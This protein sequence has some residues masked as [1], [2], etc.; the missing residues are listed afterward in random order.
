MDARPLGANVSDVPTWH[1]YAYMNGDTE[2]VQDET[3]NL[4][5]WQLSDALRWCTSRG[6]D[7]IYLYRDESETVRFHKAPPVPVVH[8]MHLVEEGHESGDAA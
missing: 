4:A 6:Y 7:H 2:G 5:D 1:L 3:R 8:H